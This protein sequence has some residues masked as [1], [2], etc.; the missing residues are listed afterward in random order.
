MHHDR[1]SIELH[2][3]NNKDRQAVIANRSQYSPMLFLAPFK[4]FYAKPILPNRV[5]FYIF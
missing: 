5:F 4:R 3:Q 1:N 2:T